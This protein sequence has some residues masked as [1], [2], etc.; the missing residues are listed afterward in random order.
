[1][2]RFRADLRAFLEEF[3]DSHRGLRLG[4]VFG[5]P[6]V[7]A[8]R[9]LFTCLMENGL[10]VLLPRDVA[11]HEIERGAA[12]Y[13][14]RAGATAAWV[15]YAPRTAVDARRLIPVLEIAARTVAEQVDAS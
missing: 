14:K 2:T 7:Y 9:R 13:T 4:R 5:R 1:M 12:P 11:R 6:A 10:I 15:I 8:G 3:V